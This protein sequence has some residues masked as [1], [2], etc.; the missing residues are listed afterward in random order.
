M[1][2]KHSSTI[3]I[4]AVIILIPI[5]IFISRGLLEKP[6]DNVLFERAR[7]IKVKNEELTQD[8]LVPGVVVGTQ[9]LEIEVLTGRFKDETFILKN[10][11]S[12]LYNVYAKKGSQIV[13]QI[14]IKDNKAE[15][16]NVY[17]Y[18]REPVLYG[19]V[20]LFFAVLIIFGGLKGFKSVIS[21]I[22]TGVMVI[23]FMIPLIFRGADPIPVSIVTVSAVI[24]ATLFL[25]GGFNKKTLSA[26]IGTVLGV[27][28]SGIISIIAGSLAHISGL[29]MEEAE[30]LISIAEKSNLQING[31]M[32]S[33]ILI[34][35]LGAIMDVGMSIASAVFE[36][37]DSNPRMDRS[38][39]FKS[40]MNIGRDVMGT[41]S[42]T[43]I[44]AFA[45][46][47]FSTILLIMAYAM[48]YRQIMNLDVIST[49]LIQGMSGSI[50]I[51]LTVPITSFISSALVK[52]RGTKLPLKSPNSL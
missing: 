29:T 44:L 37:H 17:N 1:L 27:I 40:G 39:L 19:L 47:A 26:S 2:K 4:A 32:F 30:S 23:F 31:L 12:R 52:S 20:G 3:L 16:V 6:K 41:M 24:I 10:P 28:C 34:A 8:T 22:F 45:G 15:H 13:V 21:L 11:M 7:V 49:E 42:N 38:R 9:E 46:G 14:F 43:L 18:F 51:I 25:V 36:I 50:G 35:S 33:S 48:P 5:I